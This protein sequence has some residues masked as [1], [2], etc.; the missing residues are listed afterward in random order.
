MKN[1]FLISF[2]SAFI[3]LPQMIFA[4][5]EVQPGGLAQA[6]LDATDGT[7]L[8]LTDGDYKANLTI[9]A[10]KSISLVAA[11]GTTP[12]AQITF[13]STAAL[14]NTSLT[15]DGL[16]L[17]LK[18]EGQFLIRL[19]S[20][21]VLK[22][23]VMKNCS[24]SN[25]VYGMLR[26]EGGDG[27]KAFE[28]I[29]MDN[30]VLDGTD[31]SSGGYGVWLLQGAMVKNFTLTN[32]TI[33]NYT[34]SK[35][36]F[37]VSKISDASAF[38]FNAVVKNNTIYNVC[39]SN[40]EGFIRFNLSNG[41]HINE[42][43]TFTFTDNFFT[44]DITNTD[45]SSSFGYIIR[46][47]FDAASGTM[48]ALG[49]Y[50]AGFRS[51]NHN[52]SWDNAPT[53]LETLPYADPANGDFSIPTTSELATAGVDGACIGDPRW[54]PEVE[55]GAGAYI[56]TTSET[57][58]EDYAAATSGDIL[59][60]AAGTYSS[61]LTLT[62]KD[63]TL[64]AAEGAE[65][66]WNS[67]FTISANT[68][69]LALDGLQIKNINDV[70]YMNAAGNMSELAIKNSSI[71]GVTACIFRSYSG[72]VN[73]VG[74]IELDNVVYQGN[75]SDDTDAYEL[76]YLDD[77]LIGEFIINNSTIA[78]KPNGKDMIYNRNRSNIVT[79]SDKSVTFTFTNSTFYNVATQSTGRALLYDAYAWESAVYTAKDNIFY[80]DNG[81]TNSNFFRV[82]GGT[83]VFENNLVI[84]Y[85]NATQTNEVTLAGLGL[86]AM[87]YVS[88]K[89][90][91]FT[92][93][94]NNALATASSTGGIL[95]DPRWLTDY[96]PMATLT[97]GLAEGVPT[98]AGSVDK[99]ST[100]YAVGSTLRVTATDN[101]GY[102]FVKWVDASG[103]ELGTSKSLEITVGETAASYLAV[104]EAVETFTLS[105]AAEGDGGFARFAI[106]PAGKDGKYEEY[107]KGTA[108]DIM[109][110]DN[111][112]I[113]FSAWDNGSTEL[114]RSVTL[115]KDQALT[116]TYATLDFLA[117]WDF[118]KDSQSEENG[119]PADFYGT[120]MMSVPNFTRYSLSGVEKQ[121]KVITR[122]LDGAEEYMASVNDTSE[123]G[124]FVTMV[125]TTNYTKIAV[126]SKLYRYNMTA[127]TWDLLYSLDGE[128]YTKLATSEDIIIATTKEGMTTLNADLP[129]EAWG[130]ETVYIK[131]MPTPDAEY[132]T[133]N[134]NNFNLCIDDIFIT[135]TVQIADN[136]KNPC[137]VSSKPENNGT[138]ASTNG[139]VILTFDERVDIGS[140]D[141]TLGG[142]TLT[143]T[144]VK[145]QIFLP[146]AG[147]NFS[148]N[149]TLTVPE[150][151]IVDLAGNVAEAIS[152]SF[153]TIEP[154][155]PTKKVFDLIVDANATPVSGKVVNTI[156]EAIAAAPTGLSSA[157]RYRV[158]IKNGTYDSGTS[159]L[160]LASTKSYI[161]FVGQSADGVII[162]SG[163]AW[164]IGNGVLQVDGSDIY[165]ENVS[166][167][168]TNTSTEDDRKPSLEANGDRNVYK[169]VKLLSR[170][171]THV[172]AGSRSFYYDC[173]IE[174]TVDFICGSGTHWFE[175]TTLNI[176]ARDNDNVIAAA[177][178]AIGADYGYVF[179]NN[180]I[181]GDEGQD[182]RYLL[183][184]PWKDAPRVVF[185]NTVM[186][187]L[188]AAAGWTS[189]NV[190][191]AL[192]AEY[193]SVTSTGTAVDL[194]SRT[195]VY[196]EGTGD[197]NP[198]LTAEEA[199]S[200][201]VDAALGGSDNWNPLLIIEEVQAPANLAAAGNNRLTWDDNEYAL[202]YVISRDGE[203]IGMTTEA[204]F[205]EE[206]TEG[207]YSYSV[208][209][210]NEYGGLS[211]ASIIEM[212]LTE[213][214]VTEVTITYNNLVTG[215]VHYNPASLETSEEYV[216]TNATASGYRFMGWFTDADFTNSITTIAAET[217]GAIK[218]WARW[219]AI[220][221]FVAFPTI[222]SS[223]VTIKST[224][225]NDV[226]SVI[227]ASGVVVKQVNVNGSEVQ[228]QVSD[229]TPGAYILR[230][231]ANNQTTRIVVKN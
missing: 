91:D 60:L 19:T 206:L 64:M 84:G 69:A 175:N 177:A 74:K 159:M 95:G 45:R 207:T 32:S 5:T 79:T 157:N 7:T 89:D 47:D 162:Q 169:G 161:S 154:T 174:G 144:V 193:N 102:D 139:R 166:I 15:L 227:S 211:E 52:L 34:T 56:Q 2:L 75:G 217:E 117:G 225:A 106:L 228:L 33:A 215:A 221:E 70:V 147:L 203:I 55:E 81:T 210:A 6:W 184:R 85:T 137:L 29:V 149:Y 48:T 178:T 92:I 104:F 115:D 188:P 138:D 20:G 23:L 41:T 17:D 68:G 173:F 198:V 26:A 172:T 14:D 194:S 180:T 39:S 163:P 129:K 77:C 119:R 10:D 93:Y 86:D 167:K 209:A 156:E 100:D 50:Y 82:T 190:V 54:A 150:G 76:F 40:S 187:I 113:K 25:F 128:T 222:A 18:G 27:S 160:N 213:D 181:I 105:I 201:T 108:V 143:L 4:Q 168:N 220:G 44:Q 186:D 131:W 208:Q 179:N 11:E 43:S 57:I 205:T 126:Q 226:I 223:Y 116:A 155:K 197:Y 21:A 122:T 97:F 62:E 3:S 224:E 58:A 101:F 49:N 94:E 67:T 80:N 132:S 42:A 140:G 214:V 35:S 114:A 73:E 111:A 153:K 231:Q 216:L 83:T 196:N 98:E 38:T 164:G 189:M 103:T 130:K 88:P 37:E 99:E 148:E 123:D 176:L 191:P 120:E 16:N 51:T 134:N 110:L 182:G 13:Q 63:I 219:K 195:N 112:V 66:I 158:L 229:L 46:N 165:M 53:A 141:I 96:V 1:L 125:N 121:Y 87:P 146:Y 127:A 61:T 151:A 204:Q 170:Q 199:S 90:G 109:P 22:S 24:I 192:H 145:E 200:F 171:D 71:S 230:S 36:V 12:N 124:Y 133:T 30:C 9:E 142:K 218:L 59:V 8:I 28:E 135:G 212:T 183:G 31:I 118:M 185:L 107:E 78:N 72:G 136:G 65:V 202:C 152:I